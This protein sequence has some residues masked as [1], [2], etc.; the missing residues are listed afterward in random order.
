MQNDMLSVLEEE[1]EDPSCQVP[2]IHQRTFSPIQQ[3]VNYE[4]QIE[5]EIVDQQTSRHRS[6]LHRLQSAPL[7]ISPY[8]FQ[9]ISLRSN[10]VGNN[11][12]GISISPI[13]VSRDEKQFD[14]F[15]SDNDDEGEEGAKLVVVGGALAVSNVMSVDLGRMRAI[16]VPRSSSG[17]S[18]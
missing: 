10:S 9:P 3:P 11:G 5:D 13:N 12:H 14:L 2:H 6:P 4:Y 1:E 15:S 8:T 7:A 18:S 17:T 16:P